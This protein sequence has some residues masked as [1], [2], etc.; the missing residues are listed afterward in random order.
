MRSA[1]FWDVTQ[2]KVAIVYQRFGTIGP[3]FS[4]QEIRF[5][6]PF[7]KFDFLTLEVGTNTLSRNVGKDLP[8]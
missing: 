5:I 2:P 3:F 6:D 1:L 8:P 4:G 7:K